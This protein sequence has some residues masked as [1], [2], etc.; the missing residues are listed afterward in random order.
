MAPWPDAGCLSPKEKYGRQGI[1]RS[2]EDDLSG[3]A[4]LAIVPAFGIDTLVVATGIGASGAVNRHRLALVIAL[5]EGGM[6]LIG[7]LIGSWI[8]G[9]VA[10]YAV[11]GA[12]L[13][14]ALLG[15]YEILEGFRELRGDDD[16]DDGD[17]QAEA[18]Q[19]R[20]LG[21][22]LIVAGLSVSMDELAAGL[23]AGAAQLPLIALAPALALQAGLFTYLG[24]HA[25]Q[26]LRRWAGRYGEVVA[27]AALIAAA[28]VVVLLARH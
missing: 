22:G 2:E 11:W 3:W 16:D 19:H 18:L 1:L 7:A 14:L 6:P 25:G 28:V 9:L 20:L 21:A 24:L 12:S 10:A 13:L 27:G 5:F 17:A 15:V 8:G 4:V 26:R 23:A